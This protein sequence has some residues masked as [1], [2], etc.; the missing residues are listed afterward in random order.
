ML[1]AFFAAWTT[2]A[3]TRP[4]LKAVVAFTAIFRWS[5]FSA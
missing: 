1:L 5:R 2:V 3:I 4:V